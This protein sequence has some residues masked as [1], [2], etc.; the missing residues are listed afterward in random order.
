M[1][2]TKLI[3]FQNP[4]FN[5]FLNKDIDNFLVSSSIAFQILD[6]EIEYWISHN[7]FQLLVAECLVL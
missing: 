6:L 3:G 5:L 1:Y 2:Q 4:C 7:L